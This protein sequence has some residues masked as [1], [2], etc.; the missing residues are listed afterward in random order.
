MSITANSGASRERD[1]DGMRA[2]RKLMS[3]ALTGDFT[4][5]GSLAGSSWC[6]ADATPTTAASPRG[7]KITPN[8]NDEE[9]HKGKSSFDRIL[10]RHHACFTDFVGREGEL[11]L[12]RMVRQ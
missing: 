7:A 6:N 9:H 8:E 3:L 11:D 10:Q 2:N 4:Y 12:F 1:P 5:S